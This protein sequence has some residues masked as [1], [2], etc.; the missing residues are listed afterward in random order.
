M[1]TSSV[2]SYEHVHVIL[3]I[4]TT[5]NNKVYCFSKKQK[6]FSLF[7]EFGHI[8]LNLVLLAANYCLRSDSS[9]RNL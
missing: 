3:I 9:M 4:G 8:T 2:T 1:V 5:G 7:L 6:N